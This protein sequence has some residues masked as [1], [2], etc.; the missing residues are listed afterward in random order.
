M[1]IK[2]KKRRFLFHIPHNHHITFTNKKEQGGYTST[3]KQ[4]PK[5]F[6]SFHFISSSNSSSRSGGGRLNNHHLHTSSPPYHNHTP[7]AYYRPTARRRQ[8]CHPTC[9]R[10]GREYP[11][12]PGPSRR[13]TQLRLRG[14]LQR[15]GPSR[16]SIV[17][18]FRG[19]FRRFLWRGQ[20]PLLHVGVSICF[21]GAKLI[22]CVV[23][24]RDDDDDDGDLPILSLSC[25]SR[26]PPARP[27]AP[28]A[29][30]FQ[31]LP[32]LFLSGCCEG[33]PC[34]ALRVGSYALCW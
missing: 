25:M 16:P 5:L 22:M 18:R 6:T 30:Y 29:A 11:R 34:S 13:S 12:R 4:K 14:N 23:G 9:S 33:P 10:F 20:S 19:S 3:I 32:P 1:L 24:G 31:P 27:A 8:P 7:P 15:L 17:R 26:A 28:A 2:E 21:T